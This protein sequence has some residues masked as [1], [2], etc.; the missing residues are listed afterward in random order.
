M[1]EVTFKQLVHC[2][3]HTFMGRSVGFAIGAEL[4]VSYLG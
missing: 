3:E 4:G 1:P 2:R